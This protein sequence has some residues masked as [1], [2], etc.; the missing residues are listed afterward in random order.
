VFAY[1][2]EKILSEDDIGAGCHTK[3]SRAASCYGMQ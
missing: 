1:E 3:L 2:A